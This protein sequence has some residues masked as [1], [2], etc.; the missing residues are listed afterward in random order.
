MS[1]ITVTKENFEAEIKNFKG[2]ALVDFWAEWCGP[3]KMLSP[4]VDEVADEVDDVKI[5]KIN[6]DNDRDLAI[7]FGISAI[8]CLLLFNNGEVVDRSVGLVMKD[9]ILKMIG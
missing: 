2:K 3:C 8:P 9:D 7:E 5:C 1:V 6:C 4:I